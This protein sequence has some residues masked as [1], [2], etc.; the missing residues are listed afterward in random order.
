MMQ[1]DIYSCFAASRLAD[2]T[3]TGSKDALCKLFDDAQMETI[4]RPGHRCNDTPMH[5]RFH[6]FDWTLEQATF[7]RYGFETSEKG[8]EDTVWTRCWYVLVL[9]DI[10]IEQLCINGW[11]LIGTR[12]LSSCQSQCSCEPLSKAL[13]KHVRLHMFE[14]V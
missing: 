1:R 8:V 6:I 5:D 10:S 2:H 9:W 7:C 11:I 4:A 14:H 12:I 13:A 3:F